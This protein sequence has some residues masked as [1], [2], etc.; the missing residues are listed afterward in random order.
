[1]SESICDILWSKIIE[2]TVTPILR[3]HNYEKVGDSYFKQVCD[4]V[5]TLDY[6]ENDL[7]GTKSILLI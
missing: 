1:M 6:Q 4:F 5:L 7:E 3:E 2:E